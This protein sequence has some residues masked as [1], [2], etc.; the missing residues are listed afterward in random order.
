MIVISNTSSSEREHLD[1]EIY[2]RDLEQMI[3]EVGWVLDERLPQ[4]NIIF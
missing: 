4:N 2:L 3:E 1:K